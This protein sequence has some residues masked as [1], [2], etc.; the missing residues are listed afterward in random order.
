[1]KVL[2]TTPGTPGFLFPTIGIA[3]A[4]VAKGHE[5]AVATSQTA[6]DLLRSAGLERIPRTEKDGHSFE[7]FNWFHPTAIGLQLKHIHYATKHFG[8][9]LLLGHPLTMGTYLAAELL[10]LPLAVI[11]SPNFLWPVAGDRDPESIRRRK[12][13]WRDFLKYY[14]LARQALGIDRVD[15]SQGNPFL[16]DLYLMRS[17]AEVEPEAAHFP[18]KVKLVG[19]CLWEPPETSRAVGRLLREAEETGRE[20]WFVQVGRSFQRTSYFH[21]LVA[22]AERRHWLLVLCRDRMDLDLDGLPEN[23][24]VFDYLPLGQLAPRLSGMIAV[25][26]PTAVLSGWRHGVP[27]LII[28]GGSEQWD[29]ADHVVDAGVGTSLVPEEVTPDLLLRTVEELAADEG[30]RRRCGEVSQVFRAFD[31]HRCVADHL[32]NWA[33][34]RLGIGQ[35]GYSGVE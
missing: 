20:L 28:P 17:L 19:D 29:S 18:E 1:M 21:S 8:P 5:V 25:G 3:R 24:R 33:D 10:D 30:I 22:I 34:E 2:L 27:M 7:I 12:W 13:R 32:E 14:N 11:G 4:L 9:D 23:M 31:G 15:V 35:M 16:G 26:G 6:G